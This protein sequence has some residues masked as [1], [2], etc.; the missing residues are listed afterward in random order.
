M[1]AFKLFIATEVRVYKVGGHHYADASFAKV[2]E[3]YSN[4]FGRVT[5]ATRIINEPKKRN[6]YVGI[7]AYCCNFDNIGSIPSFLVK[8]IP[9]KIVQHL[10]EADLVV[11][12][13]PSLVSL[14]IYNLIRKLSKKY[15]TEVMGCAWDAYWNHGI[16]G[17]TIAPGMFLKMK[18]MVRKADYCVYVTQIFLQNRYPNQH[19]NIG[20]SN[21]DIAKVE[22]PKDYESLQKDSFTIMTAAALDVTYKGQQYVIRAM[23]KL[24]DKYGITVK[25]YLA[26]KGDGSRLKKIAR[27]CRVEENVIF[28][29]MLSRDELHDYM[30]KADFYIQPSLQ[31]GLPRSLIEAMSCGSVCFGSDVAGIP[32]LL[33]KPFIFR[34]KKVGSLTK[35]LLRVIMSGKLSAASGRNI[36]ESR[37]YISNILDQKRSAF[38]KSIMD[39]VRRLT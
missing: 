21:V 17:K 28:L 37:K 20:V 11:M 7:D 5:L 4:D 14:K 13:L 2:L 3:R 36:R 9:L 16:V 31:E 1:V 32:E 18:K 6:G 24:K 22:K 19:D 23:R 12:R 35:T 34:R 38:Y 25:Y 27:R 33:D 8:K 39:D 15:M 10:Q 26:G 30:R 29:G